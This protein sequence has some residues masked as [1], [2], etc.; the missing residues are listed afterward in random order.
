MRNLSVTLFSLSPALAL[1]SGPTQ[2]RCVELAG[3]RLESQQ[4]APDKETPDSGI[5]PNPAACPGGLR[6]QA[7]KGTSSE[8]E[9]TSSQKPLVPVVPEDQY[10]SYLWRLKRLVYEEIQFSMTTT[11]IEK[12]C[13]FSRRK[14]GDS[15]HEE[16]PSFSSR[17]RDRKSSSLHHP[18]FLRIHRPSFLRIHRPSFHRI[19]RPSFLR[20]HRPSFLR[21]R[22]PSFLRIRRIL[23]IHHIQSSLR[24]PFYL[25]PSC[26]RR[27]RLDGLDG[28]PAPGKEP[29]VERAQERQ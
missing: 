2:S 22:H 20:I 9:T 1:G 29:G 4:A 14:V 21:I 27:T 10:C 28:Q 19:R 7:T 8:D 5:I 3:L 25:R 15:R 17:S 13:A 26:R 23:R 11:F 12:A 24:C 18:S 6:W 16:P